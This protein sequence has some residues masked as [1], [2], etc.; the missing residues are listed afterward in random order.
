MIGTIFIGVLIAVVAITLLSVLRNALV[1]ALT[2]VGQLLGS[3]LDA[4]LRIV[5]R[6]LE[7]LNGLIGRAYASLRDI[8]G[9]A[10]ADYGRFWDIFIPIL[11]IGLLAVLAYADYQL[12]AARIGPLLGLN[13]LP[14]ESDRILNLALGALYVV[15][16]LV[17]GYALSDAYGHSP[18]GRSLVFGKLGGGVRKVLWASA[19]VLA[20]ATLALAIWTV[21]VAILNIGDNFVAGLFLVTFSMLAVFATAVAAIPALIGALS[22]VTLIMEIIRV[23]LWLVAAVLWFVLTVIDKFI[24]AIVKVAIDLPARLGTSV[25]TGV[26]NRPAPEWK[27][28]ELISSLVP[29]LPLLG[30]PTSLQEMVQTDEPPVQPTEEPKDVA[31]LNGQRKEGGAT[32]VVAPPHGHRE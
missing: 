6:I 22:V 27:E 11:F 25:Y 20:V 29:G 16:L 19:A 26:T 4:A 24:E 23:L 2:A 31:H 13:Q 12:F 17:I 9:E 28:R 32:P 30:P 15:T 18:A 10:D 21:E 8:H 14:Q 1:D 5:L 7:L 3:M